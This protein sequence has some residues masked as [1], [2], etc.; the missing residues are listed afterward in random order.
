MN[1]P[2]IP[3]TLVASWPAR[4]AAY[5]DELR[6]SL[7]QIVHRRRAQ[8]L[9]ELRDAHAQ[10]RHRITEV[11][12]HA[13]RELGE[14]RM[15]RLIDELTA[16]LLHARDHAIEF[17]RQTADLVAALKFSRDAKIRALADRHG[18]TV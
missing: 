10:G 9:A 5:L 8:P 4:G 2:Q 15:E 7:H 1:C 12:Q 16:G 3:R 18:V 14:S 6:G 13:L 17:A 11:V